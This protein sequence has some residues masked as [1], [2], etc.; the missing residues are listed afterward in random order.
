MVTLRVC[1]GAVDVYLRV[2]GVP[3]GSHGVPDPDQVVQL[4]VHGQPLVQ[5]I[6]QLLDGLGALGSPPEPATFGL[7][8]GPPQDGH[9][10]ILQLLQLHGDGVD[11]LDEERVVRV[12]GV[13]KSRLDVEVRRLGVEAAV[14]WL[15][16]CVVQTHGSTPVPRESDDTATL[17]KGDRLVDIG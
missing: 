14:P 15:L 13:G 10:G 1:V 6:P 11:V 3:V 9:T 17:G 12:R 16:G 5:D 8:Q 2:S 4:V 7:V